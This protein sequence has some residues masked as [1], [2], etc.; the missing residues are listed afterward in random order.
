MNRVLR[1]AFV[2]MHS[3][4]IIGR[5]RAE[6]SARYK[7]GMYLASV[8]ARS[9][10][11]LQIQQMRRHKKR[12]GEP[13]KQAQ[14]GYTDELIIEWKRQQLL[15][16]KDPKE[17]EEG[18]KMVTACSIFEAANDPS[19]FAVPTEVESLKLGTVP[20]TSATE[21]NGVEVEGADEE[22]LDRAYEEADIN[23]TGAETTPNNEHE[24]DLE[25]QAQEQAQPAKPKKKSERKVMVWLPLTF[26]EVPK[27]G[28]FDVTRLRD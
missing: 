8:L 19:A 21:E 14:K 20:E 12:K 24:R 11:G 28:D 4:D 13:Q 17:R 23:S 25:A 7:N 6:F 27:K 2:R 9:P 5:L 15:R 22:A 26:P 10:V 18:E 3:E 16:S 1:D